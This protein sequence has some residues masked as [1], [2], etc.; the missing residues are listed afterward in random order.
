MRSLGSSVG[1]LLVLL[2]TSCITEDV[3]QDT[4]RGN[5]EACWQQLDQRYCF[6]A[7]KQEQFGL[8]WNEVYERY[9]PSV[10]EEMTDHQLFELLGNMVCELRDGH[11]NLSAAHDVA[12]YG[13]WYDDYP[14]NYSD[15]LERIYLGRAE[16]YQTAAGLKYRILDDN[17][18]YI[19]CSTFA[20]GFG[21]G[22]LH[23]MIQHLAPCD[24]LIIDVRN[25]GG[26]MVTAAQHLASIF[27]NQTKTV[28]YFSH[29]EGPGHEDFST[30]IPIEITPFIGLRWQKPVAVLTNR[31]TYSAANAFVL[32]MSEADNATI[33][34]DITGGGGGLP[35]ST[36]LPNGWT[37]RFSACPT[38]TK[39]MKP[40]E[41]GIS[42]DIKVDLQPRFLERGCD[43][44][45]EA[46]R[47]YLW[48]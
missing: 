16:D 11:V 17:I 9:S 36:E 33:I 25:N 27:F 19:R 30:P 7:Q 29:K 46:A 26:G 39:E 38:F 14:M 20:N 45:I 6:F 32:Y 44:I 13:K 47:Q 8:D 22:N 2:F 34:G 5:F 15:S 42:P 41:A 23:V 24:A 43:D 12:R 35:L 21:D 3:P 37:L 48:P 10:N 4:R 18:G 1:C 40:I 28:G 31:R